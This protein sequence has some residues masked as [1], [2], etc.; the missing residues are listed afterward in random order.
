M[1]ILYDYTGNFPWTLYCSQ[2]TKVVVENGVTG[3]GEN[4]FHDCSSLK[5]VYIT[6]EEIIKRANVTDDGD[7]HSLDVKALYTYVTQTA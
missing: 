5:S 6:G 3:I 4:T 2:I 7:V 1:R